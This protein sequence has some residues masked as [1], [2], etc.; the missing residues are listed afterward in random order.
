MAAHSPVST[1]ENAVAEATPR[2]PR[3]AELDERYGGPLAGFGS[4]D[5]AWRTLT[6][7]AIYRAIIVGL[8]MVVY[9]GFSAYPMIGMWAPKLASNAL[10]VYAALAV[11]LIVLTQLRAP[12]AAVQLTLQVFVDVTMV[13]LIMHAS[14]GARSGWGVLLLVTL[15]A[16]ALVSRGRMAF[17]H[18]AVASI[19]V[20]FEQAYQI[21]YHDGSLNDFVPPGML[22][23][24]YFVIAA[25][26]YTL[27][28][29]ARG[30]VQIAER[31]GVDLANMAQIN[32]LV[33]RDME[34]GFVII[35]EH[36]VIRQHNVQSESLVAGLK[37]AEGRALKE[38]APLLSM[39]VDEWRH[40]RTR[41]YSL[42][43]DPITQ[44]EYQMRCVAI[45]EEQHASASS[46]TVV[47]LE[48][49]SRIRSQ[50]QHMKLVALGR[51]TASIAHEI[52]NPLSSIN[53][54]A[55]LLHEDTDRS[56]ADKRLLTIIQDNA[57]RLDRLVE[58]VLYLN[59]RD[60]A[61]PET[62]DLSQMLTR[63]V[64]DFC[65]NEKIPESRVHVSVGAT[66]SG[67][68]LFG[69]FDRS[70]LDQILWNLV[71]NGVRHSSGR[72]GAVVISVRAITGRDALGNIE[73][74]VRDDGAGVPAEAQAH[75]FEPFFTT[76][77]K[78]TGLGLYIARELAEVNGAELEYIHTAAGARA[79]T[80]PPASSASVGTSEEMKSRAQAQ[81]TNHVGACFRLTMKQA[82]R[83]SA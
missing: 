65:A 64:R 5:S 33:I 20:L 81:T 75:L 16:A 4:V 60:R 58:E 32:A 47:F 44:R 54:A 71:R 45:G 23:G 34:D 30:A 67:A 12:S 21:L 7:F 28:Q 62:I 35:D 42:V 10:L 51:L 31:R 26:G 43:R 82:G 63:F 66:S 50:A 46:P 29:Y 52:R 19:A 37:G 48:D 79:S 83:G 49:A 72:D 74:D 55:E 68:A 39:L 22:A 73:L 38:A 13:V 2:A 24:S 14:G 69:T 56:D 27:A 3:L 18:A 15:A 11:G 78:G 40:D 76:D 70:H 1:P 57:H 61:H 80:V 17:F 6:R 25:L 59:R 41:M 9:W 77:A 36:G 8:M 53:H